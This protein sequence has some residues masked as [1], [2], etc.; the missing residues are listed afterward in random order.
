MSILLKK[1]NQLAFDIFDVDREGTLETCECDALLR[2]VYDVESLKDI[3]GP[4]TGE[5][6]LEEIDVNGDG[7]VTLQGVCVYVY[8]MYLWG[9]FNMW[10]Y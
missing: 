5:Q 8:C 4:P 7:D 10:V 6:L 9:S 3:E 1:K 2:M